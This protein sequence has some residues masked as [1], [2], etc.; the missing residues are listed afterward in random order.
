[1]LSIDVVCANSVGL[2]N[3]EA[4]VTLAMDQKPVGFWQKQMYSA[5]F[6]LA[7]IGSHTNEKMSA[8]YHVINSVSIS[9]HH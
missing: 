4:P 9:N 8:N 1:M 6:L 7:G 5:A 3:R 2:V